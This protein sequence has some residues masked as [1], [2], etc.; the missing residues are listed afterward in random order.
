MKR[1]VT[2]LGLASAAYIHGA[3]IEQVIVRQQW[4]WSTDVK[5]EYKI[6]GVTK[7][8]DLKVTAYN[9]DV[10]LDQS[11]L[12]AS[13][14][15][16]RLGIEEDGVGEF[17]I[18]PVKAFGTD[19][20]AIA[21]FKVKLDV[22]DT[23]ESMS[24]VLYKIIDLTSGEIDD[25]TTADLLSGGYGAVE[26]GGQAITPAG[27][28]DETKVYWTGVTNED[29]YATTSIVLRRVPSGGKTYKM[30]AVSGEIGNG[31]GYGYTSWSNRGKETQ[32][33]VSFQ[34]DFFIGVYE[35][36][37]KQ[38]NLLTSKWP[39][40]FRNATCRDTRPVEKVSW[41][42]VTGTFLPALNTLTK[43]T[44]I[45][46]TEAQWEYAYRAGTTAGLYNGKD[47]G[48]D[49]RNGGLDPNVAPLGRY[50]NNAGKS[51]PEVDVDTSQG[52]TAKVGSYQCNNWGIYDMLGNVREWCSDYFQEDLGSEAQVDP[53]G[54]ET[55]TL[56]V[57]RNGSW[58]YANN[59]N[60]SC[61]AAFRAADA[62]TYSAYHVGFRIA[63]MAE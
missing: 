6:S 47:V 11:N 35:I 15:G 56:R 37:Q 12:D 22:V 7:P 3:A 21:N 16:R 54:P 30:G 42:A 60:G 52:G 24:K 44:F 31:S 45:L 9:G 13:I 48:W 29:V 58:A 10:L 4:P 32:H 39:S 61:R 46:P 53:Q 50:F 25:V 2:F 38:Y 5:V 57:I 40:N 23:S 14:T 1:I 59:A 17:T 63:L 18:D 49:Y 51:N 33:D 27:E 41:D 55:G 19:K 26:T 36:T 28:I 8:V 43:K 62:S 20:A 34:K